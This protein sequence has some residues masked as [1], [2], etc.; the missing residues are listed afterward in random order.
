MKKSP[1]EEKILAISQLNEKIDVWLYKKL[2]RKLERA[3]REYGLERSEIIRAAV[4]KFSNLRRQEQKQILSA[5]KVRSLLSDGQKDTKAKVSFRCNTPTKN[6]IYSVEDW[7]EFL[8]KVVAWYIELDEQARPFRKKIFPP[9]IR[10]LEGI[11][12][13][14]EQEENF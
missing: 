7:T 13:I 6:F 8:N 4:R 2:I 5:D 12:Y 1:L 3:E 10:V 14:V 9:D 11:D